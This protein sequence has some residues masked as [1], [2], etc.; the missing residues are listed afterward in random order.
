MSDYLASRYGALPSGKGGTG[1]FEEHHDERQRH[2]DGDR[3]RRK[4]ESKK[5]RKKSSSSRK[6]DRHGSSRHTV[7]H[8]LD[9]MGPQPD[10]DLAPSV[11]AVGGGGFGD[12]EAPVVV[13]MTADRPSNGGDDNDDVR[14]RRR[15]GSSSEDDGPSSRHEKRRARHDSSLSDESAS[16]GS[17]PRPRH[18]RDHHRSKGRRRHDSSDDDSDVSGGRRDRHHHHRDDDRHHR[19]QRSR[20]RDDSR[21]HRQG[22]SS[23]RRRHDSSDDDDSHEGDGRHQSKRR[24]RHDSSSGND[25]DGDHRIKE[26]DG[27]DGS[28]DKMSTGHSAGLQNAAQ[29]REAEAKIRAKKRKEAAAAAAASGGG[30]DRRH[31]ETVYRDATGAKIDMHEEMRKRDAARAK[32]LELDE[33]EGEALRKGRVQREREMAAAREMEAM[34]NTSFARDR[35]DLDREQ[36]EVLWEGDP[37]AAQAARR[38]AE[39]RAAAAH[40]Q[41]PAPEAQPF[42][43]STW[44]SLGWSRPRQW[45]RGQGPG[46]QV[47]TAEKEGASL[48]FLVCRYVTTTNWYVVC[49]ERT[50]LL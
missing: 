15:H 42:W 10:D 2:G 38:R 12:D 4:K 26:E 40:L 35:T 32:Q 11:G 24:R 41:G 43:H 47:F 25:S 50:A 44:I 19:R 27:K 22:H 37:M 45:I 36:M 49:T 18:H 34:A 21:K 16:G 6:G 14:R 17:S 9:D 13:G 20:N 5:H 1:D 8:D 46:E 29:F 31:Q 30:G 33:V 23:T 39:Q 7:L 3:R 48:F 28:N